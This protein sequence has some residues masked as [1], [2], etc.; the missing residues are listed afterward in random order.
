MIIATD[1]KLNISRSERVVGFTGDNL[2]E[3][4]T[5]ELNRFYGEVDMAD[6]DF[7]LDTKIGAVNNIIDLSKAV[8]ED[9]IFLTWVIRE[10]HLMSSGSMAIQIRA[11]HG[12]VEK[13]HSSQEYV[14]VQASI[15][16]TESQ[17]DVLPSEYVIKGE[18]DKFY[19]WEI[20]A[21]LVE[22][23]ITPSIKLV[24]V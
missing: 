22:G 4:R 6:F 8:I 15:N 13:W 12:V 23:V 2:V 3:V 9:Y 24:E 16:A 1:R 5:F 11:F 17:P 21:K 14:M 7:K 10:S 20:E 18:D 19:Q